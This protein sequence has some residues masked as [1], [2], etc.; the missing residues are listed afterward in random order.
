MGLEL[1]LAGVAL[2]LSVASALVACV[3]AWKPPQ[4]R[5]V[6]E[7]RAIVEEVAADQLDLHQRVLAR[8]RKEN[9]GALCARV[10]RPQAGKP[11]SHEQKTRRP[12]AKPRPKV[13][14]WDAIQVEHW[15]RAQQSFSLPF[16]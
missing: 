14:R 9:M 1:W 8:S 2:C 11:S 10:P 13:T 5:D 15:L 12:S 7:L 16:I 6:R 4:Q 3:C